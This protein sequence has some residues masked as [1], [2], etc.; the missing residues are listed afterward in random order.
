LHGTALMRAS[1]CG[2]L[3][4]RRSSRLRPDS[5]VTCRVQYCEDDR[6]LGFSPIENG[7]REARHKRATYLT[8]D[9]REHLWIVFDGIEDGIDSSKKALT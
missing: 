5:R 7:I 9:L 1:A 3:L 4:A 2:V 6:A 8:V